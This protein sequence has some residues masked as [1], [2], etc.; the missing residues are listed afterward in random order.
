MDEMKNDGWTEI[1][2][3]QYW[4]FRLRMARRSGYLAY[5]EVLEQAE[6]ALGRDA[7]ARHRKGA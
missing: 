4:A 6:A 1:T 7:V 2:E 3:A 5:R